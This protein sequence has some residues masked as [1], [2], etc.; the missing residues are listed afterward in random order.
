LVRILVQLHGG[1]VA[2]FSDGVGRGS[3][4]CIQLPLLRVSLEDQAAAS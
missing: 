3:R 4:F 2:A 1:T